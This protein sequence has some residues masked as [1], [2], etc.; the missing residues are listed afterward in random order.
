V[1]RKN[2]CNWPH[3]FNTTETNTKFQH[4]SAQVLMFLDIH[5]LDGRIKGN[6]T[7]L[8]PRTLFLS[9]HHYIRDCVT[10]YFFSP[11]RFYAYVSVQECKSIL[12]YFT[13]VLM[14]TTNTFKEIPHH[15]ILFHITRIKIPTKI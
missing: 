9:H 8:Q 10:K 13:R 7:F 1:L 14:M 3:C 5:P 15:Y 6:T 4:R 11:F 12:Y 2:Q